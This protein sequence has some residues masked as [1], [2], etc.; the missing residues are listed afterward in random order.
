MAVKWDKH[1][2]FVGRWCYQVGKHHDNG[3]AARVF[4][5]DKPG[6]IKR[7]VTK[8]TGK[9][10]AKVKGHFLAL[11]YHREDINRGAA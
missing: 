8:V 7:T 4:D 3:W 6:E 10:E 2:W 11:K 1:K 5:K 9:S